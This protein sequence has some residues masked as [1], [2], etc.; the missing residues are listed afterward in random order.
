MKGGL[1]EETRRLGA[2]PFEPLGRFL[3]GHSGISEA[4]AMG[5]AL[6]GTASG[7]QPVRKP[8]GAG[9]GLT[10][11]GV[12]YEYVRAHP[13]AHV[14]GMARDLGLATG[15]LHYH[16][17][18]LERN[19]F[20]KTRKSGFYRFVFPT[21]VFREDQEVLLGVLSQQTPREILLL[22]LQGILTQGGLA[23]GLGHSQP[24]VSWHM[25]R[26]TRLG[27][28]SKRRTREGTLYEVAADRGDVLRFVRSY[29]P[30]TWKRW[31]GRLGGL[32]ARAGLEP[33]TKGGPLQAAR[34]MS[35]VVV[36]MI[37]KR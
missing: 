4:R 2:S 20:V 33:V 30:E 25:D 9:S 37:G 36:E 32:V 18:W 24:T 7:R 8:A 26:L 29:Y 22:L 13:G 31:A 21:M 10:R 11:R 16:L 3:G 15:D 35:P 27:V 34:N 19:G 6:A 17:F 23:K 5:T 1:S 12:I 14:R 28:V